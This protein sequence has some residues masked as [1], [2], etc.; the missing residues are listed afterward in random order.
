MS[1]ARQIVQDA[2]ESI[3]VYSPGEICLD[4]D[5]GRG[6]E[7]LNDMLDSWSNE[8]LTTFAVLEQSVVLIP[9]QYQY[10]I[11]VGA[12]IDAER[13]LRIL[14]G[15]GSAYILDPV[16]NRYPLDV[17]RQDRWNQIGNIS[18]VQANIPLYLF[19]DPQFPWGIL[20][21]FP[22]PNIAYTAFWDSYLQ[23]ARFPGLDVEAN[24]PPGY[25]MAIK[26]NLGLELG[27][28]YPDAVVTPQLLSSAQIAKANVKRTNFRPTIAQYDGE[29]VSKSKA[30][31]NI[32][33]DTEGGP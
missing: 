9:G 11:G 31:Y 17:I 13:P 2:F 14:D 28:Y 4:A 15:F 32:Y 16:G 10:T 5:L 1:T 29:I 20:N 25:S 8:S 33:R 26:R 24:L 18:S 6:F 12:Y 21:F 7:I 19:Y 22:V 30:S 23:L 3:Q 27:L